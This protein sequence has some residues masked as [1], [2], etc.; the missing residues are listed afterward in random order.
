MKAIVTHPGSAHKDDFLAC[1]LLIHQFQVP[2]FRREPTEHDLSDPSIAVVDVGGVH[3]PEQLN[4]DH[5]QFPPEHDPICALSLVLKYLGLYTDARQF[6]EWLEVAEWFDARGPFETAKWLGVDREVMGALHSPVDITLLRRFAQRSELREG[7]PIY[8]VMRFVGEDLVGFIR[9]LRERIDMI[10]RHA[11]FELIG[12]GIRAFEIVFLPRTQPMP[13]DPSS[14]LPRFIE[15]QGRSDSVI[16]MIYPDRR[17]RGYGLSRFRD[18]TRLDFTRI[19]DEPDVHFAHARGF[20]A[21]TGSTD[22]KRLAELMW[23]AGDDIA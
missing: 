2:V 10:G 12:E 8:E 20:V 14:G 4:F 9:G 17:G 1:C 19:A 13:E 3:A 5:H 21:K 6:C 23:Q 16:G 15:E 7:D 22:P 11:S 18:N